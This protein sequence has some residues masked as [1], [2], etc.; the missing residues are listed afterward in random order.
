MDEEIKGLLY[1]EILGH[2]MGY[3]KVDKDNIERTIAT[4]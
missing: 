4:G 1:G 2:E 3:A